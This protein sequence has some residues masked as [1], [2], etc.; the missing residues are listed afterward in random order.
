[1]VLSLHQMSWSFDPVKVILFLGM[2]VCGLGLAYSFLVMLTASSVWLVRNQSLFEMWWLFTSFMRY[3][4]NIFQRPLA[5]PLGWFFTFIIPVMLVISMPA[6]VMVKTFK[7][8]VVG[9]TLAMTGL[10][11]VTSRKFF[12]LALRRYRS[13]SS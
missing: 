5:W 8:W 4:R 11:L 10:L 13:A 7:P 2:F 3:P 6:E 12:R 9:F 1:M